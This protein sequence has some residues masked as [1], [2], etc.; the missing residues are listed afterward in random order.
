[1]RTKRGKLAS[2]GRHRTRQPSR[3]LRGAEVPKPFPYTA[4][5]GRV[6]WK[7]RFRYGA[8]NCQETFDTER[9]AQTFCNDISTRGTAPALKL[10]NSDR[11]AQAAL[12]GPKLTDVFNKFIA[13]KATRVRSED[14]KSVV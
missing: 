1:M 10:L 2:R 6:T 11:D 3:Q 12:A 5:N 8:Q 4:K 9:D 13:H 14:R 7:V